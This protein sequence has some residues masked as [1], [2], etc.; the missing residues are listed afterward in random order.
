MSETRLQ[1]T[2]LAV[3]LWGLS[4][5]SVARAGVLIVAGDHNIGN[6][7]DGSFT[8]PVDPGNGTWFTNILAGGTTVKVQDEFFMG[9]GQQATESINN[10]YNG[11]PGVTSSLFTGTITGA[12]LAGVSL[13]ISIL[14]ADDYSADEITALANFLADG[15]SLLFIGDNATNF[16]AENERINAALA[17]LG[18]Q[19]QLGNANIDGGQFFQTLAIAADPL[20][21]G[22]GTLSYN[23]TT[24]VV[25][26]TSLVGAVT[27]GTSIIAYEI[28]EPATVVLLASG[29]VAL[30]FVSRHRR[31]S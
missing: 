24:N 27:G 28:P 10:H 31:A 3:V 15:G 30:G 11:L 8:A 1:R 26:G 17:S 19:M 29:L 22:V 16:S 23:F 25:G 21:A 18:S 13:F 6:P 2:L 14:P 20:N 9:S 12:D 4:A 5:V 7:I